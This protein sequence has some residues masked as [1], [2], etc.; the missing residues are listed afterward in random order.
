MVIIAIL[1]LVLV[2][3]VFLRFKLL[4]FGWFS[5]TATAIVGLAILAVF[6]ALLNSLTPSGRVTVLGRVVEVAPEVAGRIIAIPVQPNTLIKAGSILF[7]IERAP[8]ETKVK[9]LRAALAEGQQRVEKMKADVVASEA[10]VAA[11]N[12]QLEPAKKRRDDIFHLAS[13]N[14]ATQFQLQDATKLVDTLSSQRDAATAKAESVRLTLS[15]TIDGEH[16]SVA[17]LKAQLDQ[18]QWELDQ[19]IVRAPSDGYV[20]AMA[21]TVGSEATP[22]RSILS[23]IVADD[24]A[25]VGFFSQNGFARLKPGARALLSFVNQP[26]RVY[27]T[28]IQ[29]VIRGVGEGQIATSGTLAS[30]NQVRMTTQYPARIAAPPDIDQNFLRLGMA[31][32]ATVISPNAGIIGLIATIIQW[33]QAYAMYLQ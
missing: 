4:R 30:E 32:T 9:Q 18:G 25:I 27:E 3:L 6:A 13:A 16:T 19:T 12:A 15:S 26:G 24:P 28:T 1:Y 14:T 11:I 5:G 10:D 17:Q 20:T 7:E 31:G 8:F 23:F 22:T 33:I 2:W 29:E 21:L